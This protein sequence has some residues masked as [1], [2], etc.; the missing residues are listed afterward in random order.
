MITTDIF[1]RRGSEHDICEDYIL[2]GKNPF[3]YVIVSDGCSSAKNTDIGARVLATCAKNILLEY[4]FVKF[5]LENTNGGDRYTSIYRSLGLTIIMNA[6][7]F[8]KTL[9]LDEQCLSATLIISFCLNNYV[10][11]YVYGDGSVIYTDNFGTVVRKVTFPSNAPFYLIYMKDVNKEKEYIRK[12]GD[13]KK[14]IENIRINPNMVSKQYLKDLDVPTSFT[15]ENK[16]GSPAVFRDLM[17]S[18]VTGSGILLVTSDGIETFVRTLTMEKYDHDDI[19]NNITAFKNLGGVF[20]KRRLKKFLSE[21]ARKKIS[22]LDD[23][24]IGGICHIGE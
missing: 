14:I 16:A 1:L 17:Y 7:T 2:N 4:D 21:M 18:D 11:T 12:Y 8:I 10:Y 9:K 20:V 5:F 3:P 6:L 23:L 19:I 24:S 22:H 15:H 13:E